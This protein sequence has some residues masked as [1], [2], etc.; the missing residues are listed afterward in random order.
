MFGMRRAV[1]DRFVRIN[2]QDGAI[3]YLSRSPTSQS[4]DPMT[5]PPAV[6]PEQVE[7]YRQI[8]W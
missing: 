5:L 1:N 3:L 6:W 2:Q 4:F 8:P 7:S